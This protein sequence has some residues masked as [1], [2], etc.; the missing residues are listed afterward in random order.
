MHPLDEI[1]Q[2]WRQEAA[3]ATF[4]RRRDMGTAFERLCTAF[5]RHDPVQAAQF[6]TVQTY[7]EWASQRGLS[8]DDAGIDLVAEL[9]DEPGAY[10]AIQ[11][12]FRDIQGSIAKG[13]IDSFLDCG[14]R[15]FLGLL[16]WVMVIGHG[17][18][19]CGLRPFLGLLH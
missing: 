10:A 1:L 12:K 7:G 4:S 15:P 14:L 8:S 16:H 18:R 9:K 2:S 17:A 13:E 6:S 11:C 19:C 3:Q 5:L